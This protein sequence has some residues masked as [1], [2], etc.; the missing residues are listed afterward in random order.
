ML[1][2]VNSSLISELERDSQRVIVT[3]K[4]NK[5]RYAYHGISDAV[6]QEWLEAP[7]QGQYFLQN[8]KGNRDYTTIKL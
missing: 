4:S 7:S 8:I 6:W 1:I 2:Q 5:S 3:F